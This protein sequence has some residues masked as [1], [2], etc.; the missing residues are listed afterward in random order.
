MDRRSALQRVGLILGTSFI[1]TEI[2]LT[3]CKTD[4]TT[5]TSEYIDF[6]SSKKLLN[7]IGNTIL[8]ASGKHLGFN[9]IN[10]I[11]TMISL[12]NDC[13]KHEDKKAILAGLDEIEKV[14]KEKHQKAFIEL[15]D[16]DKS[17]VIA[18]IDKL[19]FDKNTNEESKPKYFKMLKE[20]ALLSYFTSEKVATEIFNYTKV[21]GKYDGAMKIDPNQYDTMFG[22]G[23]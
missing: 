21:P 14:S 8:P 19:Y 10:A 2:F 15:S 5:L 4:T 3:G 22:L 6:T 23:L 18:P 12:L 1:S 16:E 11:D 20:A 9:G 13:Y 17:A 7:A